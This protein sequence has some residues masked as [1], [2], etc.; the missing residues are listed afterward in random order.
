MVRPDNQNSP[1]KKIVF[2]VPYY[3]IHLYMCNYKILVSELRKRGWSSDA[4]EFEVSPVEEASHCPW[5]EGIR[6]KFRMAFMG[7]AV[8]VLFIVFG[9]W[10]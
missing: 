10:V 3:I 6:V 5:D 2:D 4:E 1:L 7:G 9:L 8:H